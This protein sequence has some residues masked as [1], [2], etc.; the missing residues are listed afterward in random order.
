MVLDKLWFR[1]QL[2]SLTGPF[3]GEG[4][5]VSSGEIHG[6]RIAAGRLADDGIKVKLNIDIAERPLAIEVDGLLAAD[7][8]APGF[9]G[10][11]SMSRPVGSVKASGKTVVNEPWKLTGKM[12]A[13]AQSALMEQVEFQYGPEQRAAK[14]DGAAEIKF[15]ERPRLQG[16]LSARQIDLDRLI[17]TLRRSAPPA[18]RSDAGVGG[19]VQRHDAAVDS[20]QPRGEH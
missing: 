18:G 9:D 13:N 5:F 4:A 7:R 1:G 14:L 20:G 17:A 15:G 11:F 12:K 8:T 2:R 10:S 16:A 19:I 6:Y 3:R